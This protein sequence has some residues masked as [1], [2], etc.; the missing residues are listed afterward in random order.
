MNYTYP[1]FLN[2]EGR[3]CLVAGSGRL[4][5]EKAAGLAAAGAKVTLVGEAAAAE[6]AGYFLAVAAQEDPAGN[7]ELFAAAERERV[8]FNA[9]DDPRHCRFVYPSVHR[10]GELVIAVS[11]TGRCPALAVRL[12]QRFERE[13]GPPFAEF[14][15][16]A[17]RLREQLKREIPDAEQRRRHWYRLTDAFLEESCPSS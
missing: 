7:A 6:L 1:V 17:G 14:L 9:L 3:P 5:E 15:L 2:L 12:R 16:R 11:T 10:Q 13:F 8:L 4:A